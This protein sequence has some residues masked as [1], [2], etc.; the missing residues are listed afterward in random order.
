MINVHQYLMVL[1]DVNHDPTYDSE[2]FYSHP[3][4]YKMN[5]TVF[6][7]GYNRCRGTHMGVYVGILCGEF[8]DQLCWPFNGS[9][10]VQAYNRT[11]EQWSNERTIVMNEI[12]C[13]LKYVK[14]CVDVLSHTCWGKSD[15]LSLSEL[16][17]DYVKKTNI[18]RLRITK[19][20]IYN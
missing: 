15:F 8:D 18:V 3:G 10:T 13:G 19:V 11:T 6:P 9:I 20:E 4:G 14:R 12:E 7:N 5:I 17:N 16:K 1:S 2:P